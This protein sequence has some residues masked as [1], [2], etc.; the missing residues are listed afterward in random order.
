MPIQMDSLPVELLTPICFLACTDGGP[1]A[2][3]L[4]L[5][6]RRIHAVSRPA[7]F[8]SVAF[9]GP[10]VLTAVP[11][12]LARMKEEHEDRKRVEAASRVRHLFVS[13]LPPLAESQTMVWKVYVFTVTTL[14]RAV[15]QDVET[16]SLVFSPWGPGP[17]KPIELDV[18]FPRVRE[19]TVS[20]AS[21]SAPRLGS[22][23]FPALR[24]LHLLSG[25]CPREW[26]SLT[27]NVTHL[28][29]SELPD[30]VVNPDIS[31]KDLQIFT[32]E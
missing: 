8:H 32:S 1:T 28:R 20:G 17:T 26:T 12:F 25:P 31:F 3:S 10:R 19:L 16:L 15:A 5:V 22:P 21:F 18:E 29:L 6:S 9:S 24:R 4:S 30:L 27:P 7:R 11:H 13:V 14:L 2:C 23:A